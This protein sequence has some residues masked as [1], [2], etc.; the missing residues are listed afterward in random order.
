MKE[1]YKLYQANEQN[2]ELIHQA[3]AFQTFINAHFNGESLIE[4]MKNG[5]KSF[6]KQRG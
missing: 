6:I 1:T 3:T 2:H 4:R 5:N